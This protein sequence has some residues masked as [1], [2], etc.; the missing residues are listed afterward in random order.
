MRDTKDKHEAD[1]FATEFS[2]ALPCS[3]CIVSDWK[4][5]NHA[6]FFKKNSPK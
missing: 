6:D 3:Y 2:C 1:K 4:A 5:A